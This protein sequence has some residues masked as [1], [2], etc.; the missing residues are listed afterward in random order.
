MSLLKLPVC[1]AFCLLDTRVNY[2]FVDG[3]AIFNPDFLL[4]TAGVE[5]KSLPV[6]VAWAC[7][8]CIGLLVAQ[9]RCAR[10]MT[11]SVYCVANERERDL[12]EQPWEYLLN[13]VLESSKSKKSGLHGS[14]EDPPSSSVPCPPTFLAASLASEYCCLL[15]HQ[16]LC[17]EVVGFGHI[18]DIVCGFCPV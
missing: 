8:G 16:Y 2:D 7:P 13:E 17:Q 12:F 15:W 9:C 4:S 1:C 10:A 3:S 11:Q 14:P 6:S 18:S 5:E